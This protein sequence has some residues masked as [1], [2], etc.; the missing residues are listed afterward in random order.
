MKQTLLILFI[1]VK[2]LPSQFE[3]CT[4]SSGDNWPTN[5]VGLTKNK[6]SSLWMVFASLRVLHHFTCPFKIRSLQGFPRAWMLQTRTGRFPQE[7]SRRGDRGKAGGASLG[8]LGQSAHRVARAVH[9][10]VTQCS[11]ITAFIINVPQ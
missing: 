9:L 10:I 1:A 4:Y 11:V 5:Y 2:N 3:R 8:A 7:E 6:E